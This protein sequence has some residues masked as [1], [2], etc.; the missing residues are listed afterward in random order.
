M[1]RRRRRTAFPE[2]PR[3]PWSKTNPRVRRAQLFVSAT[4]L[5]LFVSE[6]VG[7]A[8]EAA[9]MGGYSLAQFIAFAMPAIGALKIYEGSSR[10]RWSLVVAEFALSLIGVY[11]LI[12]SNTYSLRWWYGI[13]QTT[14]RS[15]G[16]AALSMPVVG[17]VVRRQR[18][19]SR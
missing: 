2:R 11:F 1:R 18:K 14:A 19:L 9:I 4:L 16:A 13:L 6:L 10:G 17:R 12:H 7:F 5:F 3:K 8:F 15:A